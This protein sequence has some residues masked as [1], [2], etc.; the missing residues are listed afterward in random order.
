VAMTVVMGVRTMK[1]PVHLHEHTSGLEQLGL[2][3]MKN[4]KKRVT[5]GGISRCKGTTWGQGHPSSPSTSL[6]FPSLSGSFA[7]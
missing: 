3:V 6:V 5:I 1:L 7:A 2:C 4:T